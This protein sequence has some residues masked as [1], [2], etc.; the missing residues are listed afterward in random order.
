MI[1]GSLFE[2]GSNIVRTPV[3]TNLSEQRTPTPSTRSAGRFDDPQARLSEQR[4]P[5]PSTRSTGWAL[6]DWAGRFDDPRT[7]LS[8]QRTPKPSTPSA[9]WA[10]V[11]R[12]GRFDDP[13]TRLSEHRT[14][15][16]S[17][18][19]AG[20]FDDPR[21]SSR[22]RPGEARPLE[23]SIPRAGST[24]VAQRDYSRGFDSTITG[25]GAYPRVRFDIRQS[26][27]FLGHAVRTYVRTMFERILKRPPD[28]S[29]PT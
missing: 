6:V 12:A 29:R 7:R 25:R 2:T 19:S 4:I 9:G 27:P 8:E 3:R 11:D 10:L 24:A 13:R 5:T 15:M 17:A 28:R 26:R 23:G 18:R 20:R 22:P 14:P 21:G 1:A 16:P